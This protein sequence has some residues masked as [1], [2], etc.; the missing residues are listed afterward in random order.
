MKNL[1]NGLH[2]SGL[3]SNNVSAFLDYGVR[4]CRYETYLAARTGLEPVYR[5]GASGCALRAP[6]TV[7]WSPHI[8]VPA[9]GALTSVWQWLSPLRGLCAPARQNFQSTP[10]I[11]ISLEPPP[12]GSRSICIQY[13][14][15]HRDLRNVFQLAQSHRPSECLP[16]LPKTSLSTE[17]TAGP[18]QL[19]SP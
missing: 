7:S 2:P 5:A 13:L 19:R 6:D 9:S 18:E 1:I 4:P 12:P 11:F 15:R 16:R 14:L 3:R 17:Q 10:D 8:P